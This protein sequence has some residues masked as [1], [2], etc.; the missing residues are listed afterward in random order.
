MRVGGY[1]WRRERVLKGYCR[2]G[3][4]ECGRWVREG[5]SE[6]LPAGPHFARSPASQHFAPWGMARILVIDDEEQLRRV[7]VRM[8]EA[9]GHDVR[10]AADGA[11]GLSLWRD[12]GAD[13]VLTDIHMAGMT[14]LEV[15]GELRA[16][17]PTIPVIAMSGSSGSG[18]LD[19]LRRAEL[20]GGVAVLSKPFSWD[21]L[22]AA[23]AAAL[24]LP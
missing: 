18:A 19:V 23:I 24:P 20:L 1:L 7:V 21:T 5:S 10:E 6:P 13:L 15:I 22:M 14:G 17:A 16:V 4:A 12:V 11:S 2:P 8:L 3:A 9:A